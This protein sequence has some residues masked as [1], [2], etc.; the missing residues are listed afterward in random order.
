MTK[1]NVNEAETSR[2]AQAQPGSGAASG[3]TSPNQN[4]PMKT[5]PPKMTKQQKLDQHRGS[6]FIRVIPAPQYAA[7]L[8]SS[9]SRY[10]YD[11]MGRRTR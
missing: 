2:T 11:E 7:Y 10:E 9:A 8:Q 4:H 5:K 6:R 1:Q 3:S